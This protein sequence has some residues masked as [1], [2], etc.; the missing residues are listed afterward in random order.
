MSDTEALTFW[1]HID[2]LRK[3]LLRSLVFVTLAAIAG[4]ALSEPAQRFL[5][6]PFTEYVP[7]SLTLLAPSEGF[8]IQIKISLMLGAL[9]AAPFVA[10]QL[11]GFVGPGLKKKEKLW[12]WPITIAGTILF[13]GGVLFAWYVIPGALQFL[14]SFA[15]FGIENLWSLK[16][17]INL[18]LFLLLAFGIIFQLPLVMGVLIATGLVS[19]KF[20]RKHRRYAIVAIFILSALAT[21]TTDAVTMLLMVAP[22]MILYE[23]SIWVGVIIEG[24]RAKKLALEEGN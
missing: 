16:S 13:W 12:L 2:E 3:R 15:E 17:Y 6:K 9:F 23:S 18:L 7:G 11:Y 22:M 10:W 14:G 4:F 5:I 20:F 8:V 24:K 1:D 21:P 19:S